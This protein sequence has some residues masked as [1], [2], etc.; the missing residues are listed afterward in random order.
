MPGGAFI[1]IIIQI[2][3]A[4][5]TLFTSF[6]LRS[7]AQHLSQGGR[8]GGARKVLTSFAPSYNPHLTLTPTPDTTA[9]GARKV[10]ISAPA[11]DDET[12]TFVVGVNHHL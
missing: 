6:L 2:F 12:P 7:A 11:K 9:T 1:S 4:H 8:R 5:S 3:Y 10:V